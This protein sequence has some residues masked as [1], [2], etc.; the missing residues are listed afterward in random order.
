MGIPPFVTVLDKDFLIDSFGLTHVLFYK[1]YTV[2]CELLDG[3]QYIN[4]ALPEIETK[5]NEW[6][7]TLPD[8]PDAIM[9]YL[10]MNNHIV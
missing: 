9:M 6:I 1:N 2:K 7:A 5:L 4:A 8:D 10:K 3:W